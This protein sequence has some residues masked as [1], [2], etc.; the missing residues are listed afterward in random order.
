MGLLSALFGKPKLVDKVP[1]DIRQISRDVEV[2]MQQVHANMQR[3]GDFTF[4]YLYTHCEPVDSHGPYAPV[5]YIRVDS[6]IHQYV[7]Q[8]PVNSVDI[9]AAIDKHQAEFGEFP[10]NLPKA[11]IRWLYFNMHVAFRAC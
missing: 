6:P 3:A 4:E 10:E 5:I 11:R 1:S 9:Q 7:C 8:L 2:H